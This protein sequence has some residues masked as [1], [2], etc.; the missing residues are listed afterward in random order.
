MAK[1]FL[2]AGLIIQA[3]GEPLYPRSKRV[4]NGLPIPIL[5]LLFCLVSGIKSFREVL[6]QGEDEARALIGTITAAA[7]GRPG[8]ARDI[9]MIMAVRPIS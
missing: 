7:E 5:A 3:G 4:M 1:S 9:E 2:A 6:S 8:L